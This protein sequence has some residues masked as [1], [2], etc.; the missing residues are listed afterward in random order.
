VLCPFD[1]TVDTIDRMLNFEIADDP[2]YTGLEIQAFDQDPEYGH[3]LLAFLTRRDNGRAYIYHQPGLRLDP[4]QFQ[5]GHGLGGWTETAL[6]P[7]RL[8]ITDRGVVAA[9]GFHDDAG[10]SIDVRI[11][12]RSHRRR[13]PGRL[14]APFGAAVENPTSLLLA[15]MGCFDLLRR[16]GREF[17]VVLDDHPLRTGSLPGGWLHRRRL[18]KY[19]A[20]IVVVRLNQAQDGPIQTLDPAHP[21]NVELATDSSI[22]GISAERRGHHVRLTFAPAVPD[23]SQLQ[24]GTHADGGWNLD[25]DDMSIGGRWW[26]RRR[27]QRVD[28]VLDVTRGWKPADLP[29]LMR[30]MTAMV[31]M[32][33][34]W[35]TSYRWTAAITLA[36]DPWITSQ[37]ERKRD[38]R[39]NTY[40]RL[41]RSAA[42]R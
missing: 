42:A 4:R 5:V 38:R 27:D 41:T 40:R 1:L 28:L 17:H 13:R 7:A 29:P 18:V 26:A 21:G 6:A 24:T 39:D 10:R 8:D 30:L 32:F 25:I 16:R 31:R 9:L 22:A 11:D 36:P 2:T 37:W 3:G 19:A 33:R 23:L 14:L 34:T 35:P 20:D 15:Y 12:D